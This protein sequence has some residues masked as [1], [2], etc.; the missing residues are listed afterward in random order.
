MQ[1]LR[2]VLWLTLSVMVIPF[3]GS[4]MIADASVTEIRA[5]LSSNL[6]E[7]YDREP[8]RDSVQVSPESLNEKQ[9]DPEL[10]A[11]RF[12][13][14]IRSAYARLEDLAPDAPRFELRD[15]ETVDRAAFEKLRAF[16][17]ATLPGGRVIDLATQRVVSEDGT[18][19]TTY[20]FEWADADA[21][22]LTPGGQSAAKRTVAE[23]IAM[24]SRVDPA[25]A[26]V[27]FLTS[28][29]VTVHFEGE[30][31][32]YRAA[33]LWVANE[34][35]SYVEGPLDHIVQG[36]SVVTREDK[37]SEEPDSTPPGDEVGWKRGALTTGQCVEDNP[38]TGDTLY[39]PHTTGHTSGAHG[40][41]LSVTFECKCNL[42]C[43]QECDPWGVINA[44]CRE[45]GETGLCHKISNPST[46]VARSVS[47]PGNGPASCSIGIGCAWKE[48]FGCLC[49]SP[50][51][52]V[53]FG[54]KTAGAGAS[55][56]VTSFDGAT[57]TDRLPFYCSA[58]EPL[59]G[60][61]GSGGGSTGGE[62]SGEESDPTPLPD[63]SP[64]L[65][66]LDRQGFALTDLED[67]VHF[68]ID[69]DGTAE[70]IAWTVPQSGDA[71][72]VLDRNANGI[73]DSGRELFGNHSWQ[74]PSEV[75]NGFASLAVF[76]WEAQGG[77]SDGWITPDDGTF[78]NLALW[79]DTN[80]DGVSQPSELL[81]LRDSDVLAIKLD[82]VESRRRD[83]H[84]NEI[85]F[86][87]L[88]RLRGSTTTV[89]DVFLLVQE[90]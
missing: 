67:G 9:P 57:I 70:Q 84:G 75:P 37:F 22:L 14:R 73:I 3:P 16:D 86:T 54:N 63:G 30:V 40:P 61:G 34:D 4:A 77:N 18:S 33:F 52:T 79:T 80:H 82:Y 46:D 2:A 8:R 56:S 10:H 35:G 87:S 42:D 13:Q 7:G 68:D 51:I 49:L 72:L 27:D 64:L 85:R 58:C 19:K 36:L 60:G 15:F 25:L 23:L 1:L 50:S 28:Y 38:L 78:Q 71:F 48:C 29:I 21:H 83:R 32:R 24:N 81:P 26:A 53:Q 76:D 47:L 12:E 5:G 6:Q 69:R 39:S 89:A 66:D 43:S 88:V 11:T 74:P 90:P 59:A 55:L 41:W 17:V 20:R 65:I 62:E 45:Q 31:R 44:E